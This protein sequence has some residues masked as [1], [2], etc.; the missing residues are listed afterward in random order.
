M[1]FS[2]SFFF[3]GLTARP[4]FLFQEIQ[5]G[6]FQD[7]EEGPD[8]AYASRALAGLDAQCSSFMKRFPPG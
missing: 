6:W 8:R 3:S 2:S 5:C 7:H 4:I 1:V